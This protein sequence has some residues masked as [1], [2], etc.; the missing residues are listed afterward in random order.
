MLLES[1]KGT[2]ISDIR[3]SNGISDIGLRLRRNIEYRYAIVYV[4]V[5]INPFFYSKCFT[6][7]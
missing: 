5:L 3:Y 2:A 4:L 1:K 6:Q 7:I